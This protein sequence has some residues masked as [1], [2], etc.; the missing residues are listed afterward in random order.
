MKEYKITMSGIIKKTSLKAL[1][2]IAFIWFCFLPPYYFIMDISRIMEPGYLYNN[3]FGIF[4]VTMLFSTFFFID[5]F[6]FCNY[7]RYDKNTSLKIDPS[8]GNM[9]Y[10]KGKDIRQFSPDNIFSLTLVESTWY[11]ISVSYAIIRFHNNKPIIISSLIINNFFWNKYAKKYN[12]KYK[13]DSRN[14]ILLPDKNE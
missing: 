6:Y 14:T 12:I 9:V 2:F 5:F 11:T 10:Q 1:F 13:S 8:N 4:L 3:L 7:Y